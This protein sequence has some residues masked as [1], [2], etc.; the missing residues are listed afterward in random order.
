VRLLFSTLRHVFGTKS[1]GHRHPF[2][3]SPPSSF[4]SLCFD[5]FFIRVALLGVVVI[6]TF[7][8]LFAPFLTSLDNV[9]QVLHRMFPFA[10]GLFEDKVANF[11][12]AS[13]V[14]FRWKERF[15][16]S[17]LLR[18]SLGLT[19]FGLVPTAFSVLRR[20]TLLRFQYCLAAHAFSFFLFSFQVH[21]KTILLPLLPL[22]CLLGASRRVTFFVTWL[23]AVASF[24]MFPLLLK[25]GLLVP[26]TVSQL[27]YLPLAFSQ[28][29][30]PS[31]GWKRACQMSLLLMVAIHAANASGLTHRFP[32][33]PDLAE[34]L[35]AVVGAAH[36]AVAAL[37][38]VVVAAA[39]GD[40]SDEEKTDQV[41]ESKQE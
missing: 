13:H 2:V 28:S 7:A 35:V 40:E 22:V 32:R 36:F 18:M 17:T 4:Y 3:V 12:C 26:Y 16:T 1:E 34:L 20:P 21:E 31:V 39:T 29:T 23:S 37:G 11:W 33:Y 10:R 5:R 24:T 8:I 41:L 9:T 25:D 27:L 30:A 19:L 38:V 6:F 14:I 15:E